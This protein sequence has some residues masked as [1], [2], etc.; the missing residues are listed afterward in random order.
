MGKCNANFGDCDGNV[1]N[2]CELDLTSDVKNCGSC[3]MVCAAPNAALTCQ[4][5]MC[6][7]QSCN[8]GFSDC[9]NNALNGCESIVSRDLKNCGA[10]GVVCPVPANATAACSSGVCGLGSCMYGW[11]DCNKN[12]NDGCETDLLQV[13][14]CGACGAMCAVP[15]N[16][17]AS[18]KMATCAVGSC[19]PGY[20]DCDNKFVNGCEINVLTDGNNCGGCG[21][22]CV[23]P[24]NMKTGCAAGKCMP[25]GCN[26]GFVKLQ[27]RPQRRL[28][29]GHR[30]RPEQLRR[31]QGGL[32]AEP[33][34][35]RGRRMQRPD[36][37]QQ[38]EV[39]GGQLLDG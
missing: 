33:A 30:H 17:V 7:L 22:V 25:G 15:A 32:P 10:C 38:S 6:Q 9:D 19:G 4:G 16:G 11:G 21:S 20:S 14:N 5:A 1:L 28:R 27:Q 26:A 36:L 8:Q 37:P 12:V 13:N 24:A 18:C 39:A 2:G 23:P 34:R 29:G 35:L 31:V 3:G